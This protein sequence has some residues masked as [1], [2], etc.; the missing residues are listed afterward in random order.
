MGP[1]I[2]G[3]IKKII[4]YMYR[5]VCTCVI[6]YIVMNSFVFVRIAPPVVE[7]VMQD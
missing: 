6:Q 3:A 7:P 2:M 1:I 4:K 5:C